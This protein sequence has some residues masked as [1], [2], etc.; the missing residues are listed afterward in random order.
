MSAFVWRAR[1]LPAGRR[2]YSFFSSK[3]G[4]GRYFNSAKPSVAA[5]TKPAAAADAGKGLAKDVTTETATVP[6]APAPSVPLAPQPLVWRALPGSA[7]PVH[8]HPPLGAPDCRLHQFFAL[9][10]PL[11]GLA[12]PASALFERAPVPF[13]PRAW[14]DADV[15]VAAA[16]LEPMEPSPEADADV[17]RQLARTLVMN[18]L[19]GTV[20]FDA[21]LRKLGLDLSEGRERV[22]EMDLSDLAIHLDSVK[23]KRRKKMKKHK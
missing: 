20:S 1:P 7:P 16:P 13:A 8:F 14:A 22:E 4:G 5:G 15:E 21:A 12:Q 6:A 11:L 18:R 3:S 19:G 2:A 9:D 10:R 17:A 23:R